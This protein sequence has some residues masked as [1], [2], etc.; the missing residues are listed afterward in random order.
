MKLSTQ[1]MLEYQ[2]QFCTAAVSVARDLHEIAPKQY[3]HIDGIGGSGNFRT[4]YSEDGSVYV[5]FY[6]Y[7]SVLDEAMLEVSFP[8]YYLELD[9]HKLRDAVEESERTKA[10][11][12]LR[13]QSDV[14]A[15]TNEAVRVRNLLHEFNPKVFEK[16]LEYDNVTDSISV[17]LDYI[18]I[19]TES[20]KFIVPF[21]LLFK[22]YNEIKEFSKVV[23]YTLTH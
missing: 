6:P 21:N 7:N 9:V 19:H 11:D 2:K 8:D 14:S 4:P 16:F 15:F 1:H 17:K 12:L 22:S 23:P 13:F 3:R 5:P 18:V 10:H 20:W